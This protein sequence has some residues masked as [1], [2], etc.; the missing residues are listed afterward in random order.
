MGT[1]PPEPI[2]SMACTRRG[3]PQGRH[4]N[5]EVILHMCVP[6]RV[7]GAH[8]GI[9]V[10]DTLPIHKPRGDVPSVGCLSIY[11]YIYVSIYIGTY[12]Y[13]DIHVHVHAY[14]CAHAH[15]YVQDQRN[16]YPVYDQGDIG[17]DAVTPTIG[18]H[19]MNLIC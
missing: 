11:I 18:V 17:R 8:E 9:L 10:V 13:N 2:R 3:C 1:P 15:T 5:E 12:V 7:P 6:G 4:F 19:L 16:P 14:A